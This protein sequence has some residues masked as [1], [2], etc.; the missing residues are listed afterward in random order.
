[1]S[2]FSVTLANLNLHASCDWAGRYVE[3]ARS[4]FDKP[5][6]SFPLTIYLETTL[7]QSL[8]VHIVVDSALSSVRLVTIY[9]FW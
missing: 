4:L 8:I 5:Y 9:D 3:R 7:T 6:I 1:M 2:R